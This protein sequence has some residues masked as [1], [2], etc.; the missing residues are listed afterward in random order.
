M[1]VRTENTSPEK[2]KTQALCVFV[3]EKSEDPF[4]LPKMHQKIDHTVKQACKETKGKIG[5]ISVIHT[6]QMVPAQRIVISGI[7]PR[8][9]VTHESVR[10]SAGRLAKRMSELGIDEFCIVIPDV[11]R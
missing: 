5:S 11:F 1:T 8:H 7:G 6:H 10:V 2:K 3:A 4:G 9:K